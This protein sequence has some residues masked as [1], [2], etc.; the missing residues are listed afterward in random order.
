MGLFDKKYCDICGAQIKLLGNK[1]LEDGNCCKDCVSKL[2]PWFS[3]RRHSTVEEIKAQIEYREAN[4]AEVEAFNVT[5]T[6]GDNTKV[7]I[8]EDQKKFIVTSSSKWRDCNPDVI[9]FS[10][11]TGCNTRIDE[12]KSEITTKGP[13]DH[14]V[15]CNPQRFSFDYDFYVTIHIN[16][17]FFDEINFRI[18]SSSVEEVVTVQNQGSNA[19]MGAPHPGMNAPAGG[20]RPGMNAPAGG[21]RPGMNAPAGGPRPGA[22]TPAGGPRPGM[23]APAGGPRPGMNA[24]AGGPRPGMNAPAGGPRPGANVPGGSMVGGS[25]ATIS[26]DAVTNTNH[27]TEYTNYE[28]ALA[29]LKELFTGIRETTRSEAAAAAAPM[30]PVKCPNCGATGLPTASGCCEYC[31]SALN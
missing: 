24:P 29:E 17:P 8:D 31:G 7:L 21:P 15:S 20:P 10:S 28:N 16:N 26:V 14:E 12:S 23:N 11:V 1:K 3:D 22:S 30:V 13:D 6:I 19:P 2:S 25:A 27:G 5:R 9:P 4:K 18:N